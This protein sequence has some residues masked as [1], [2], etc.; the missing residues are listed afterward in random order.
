[1]RRRCGAPGL[2]RHRARVVLPRAPARVGKPRRRGARPRRARTRAPLLQHQHHHHGSHKSRRPRNVSRRMPR[3]LALAHARR[4]RTLAPAAGVCRVLPRPPLPAR[5]PRRRDAVQ[6]LPR[7]R[8]Q[9]LVHLSLH[10]QLEVGSAQ[11][12]ARLHLVGPHPV[13]RRRA[14]DKGVEAAGIVYFQKNRAGRGKTGTPPI[15]CVQ[16]D[17][18]QELAERVR[19]Q[20]ARRVPRH[21]R[22]YWIVAGRIRRMA[23]NAAHRRLGVSAVVAL[24]RRL[25]HQNAARRARA[26]APAR[27]DRRARQ[28]AVWEK[29]P[30]GVRGRDRVPPDAEPNPRLCAAQHPEHV[31]VRVRRA[32]TPENRQEKVICAED[33][34]QETRSVG[35]G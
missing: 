6:Q 5:V 28:H 31:A 11:G 30:G 32:P 27:V 33:A 34:R 24:R 19:K 25:L 21:P 35:N 9:W 2:Q 17:V 22:V 3:R 26:G 1:M 13:Q 12:R 23:R 10:Q 15:K 20:A 8:A 18:H 14:D 29:K 4:R 16:R 7:V